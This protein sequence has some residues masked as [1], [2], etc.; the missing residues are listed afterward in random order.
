M[1]STGP[2]RPC[3]RAPRRHGWPRPPRPGRSARDAG[4]RDDRR[5]RLEHLADE[6]DLELRLPSVELNCLIAYAG[7]SVLPVA[8]MT[9]FADRYW[10]SRPDRR[11]SSRRS[12]AHTGPRCSRRDGSR[13]SECAAA[14]SRLCR[15]R[16]CR[17]TRSRRASG[18]T[19]GRSAPRGTAR[20][21]RARADVVA[22]ED[23][24][25]QVAVLRLPVLDR[26]GEKCRAAG[27]VA[28][29][30]C[31]PGSRVPCRS[32]NASRCTSVVV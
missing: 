6:A 5:R 18:L 31:A 14:L 3:P 28:V 21:Q 20:S 23:R 13:R 24:R 7:K 29:E 12:P 26:L 25:L 32:L 17:Q 15:T 1:T 11:S 8:V 2:S 9:T 19:R 4:R 30:F 10:K 27:E 16:G 22:R